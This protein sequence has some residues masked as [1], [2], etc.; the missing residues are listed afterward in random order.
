[1]I[2]DLMNKIM[3]KRLP[4]IENYML[5]PIEVQE[6]ILKDIVKSAKETIWGKY[7]DYKNTEVTRSSAMDDL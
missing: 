4:Q 1:M 3:Q 5:H 7:Y 6:K 2:N